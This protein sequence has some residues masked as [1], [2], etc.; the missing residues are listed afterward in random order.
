MTFKRPGNT[1]DII[2]EQTLDFYEV[3]ITTFQT[4]KGNVGGRHEKRIILFPIPPGFAKKE[5]YTTDR[6]Q[7]IAFIEPLLI[8]QSSSSFAFTFDFISACG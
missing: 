8:L 6:L 4:F 2:D 1:E 7:N 5:K 3:L